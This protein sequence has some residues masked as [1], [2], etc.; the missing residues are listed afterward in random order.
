MFSHVLALPRTVNVMVLFVVSNDEID[1]PPFLIVLD[2]LVT[3]TSIFFQF[4]VLSYMCAYFGRLVSYH[5]A[6]L[7]SFCFVAEQ[8]IKCETTSTGLQFPMY[9]YAATQAGIRAT[10]VL[11][12]ALGSFKDEKETPG[13]S[14]GEGA[15]RFVRLTTDEQAAQLLMW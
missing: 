13:A 9:R 14:E 8:S 11:D 1:A 2:C 4:S 3:G 6:A 12:M 15:Q 7:T 10:R 5:I